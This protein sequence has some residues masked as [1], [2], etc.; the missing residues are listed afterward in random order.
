MGHSVRRHLRVEIDEY[1]T[2]IRRFIPG[3]EG[4]IEAA[5]DAVVA[6]APKHVLDLGAGTGA[7]AAAV[8]KRAPRAVVELVDLDPE[9]LEGARGRLRPFGDQARFVVA[10]FDHPFGRCDAI[11]ASLSLHHIPTLSA[12]RDLFGRAFRALR[13]GGALVNADVTVPDAAPHREVAFRTWADHQVACGFSEEEVRQ[14]FDEWAEEDTYFPLEVEL[15]ALAAEGF[16]ARTVW[17]NGVSTV[18][19]GRRV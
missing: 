9:M 19:V 12:K 16:E 5:A 3:Y 11:M 17:R 14:H 18:L 15:E 2:S 8:L 13:P 10:S 6:I 7:L 4:M 1:D